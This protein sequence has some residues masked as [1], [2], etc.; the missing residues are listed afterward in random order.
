MTS[1]LTGIERPVQYLLAVTAEQP[2]HL[3]MFVAAVQGDDAR[4]PFHPARAIPLPQN[5]FE[6]NLFAMP[7]YHMLEG[8]WE[9]AAELFDTLGG[10]DDLVEMLRDPAR[11][12]QA[13]VYFSKH[14]DQ[15]ALDGVQ[16]V[17][18]N[19][20][21]H[22]VFNRAQWVVNNRRWLTDRLESTR[23][24][25]ADI[26]VVY[27]FSSQ[28]CDLE[29]VDTLAE[30]YPHLAFGAVAV[31]AASKSEKF[32]WRHAQQSFFLDQD[33]PLDPLQPSWLEQLPEAF[34]LIG[35]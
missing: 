1:N 18:E 28:H 7:Y 20:A 3:E 13:Q 24:R 21:R 10:H 33:R 5:L 17:R 30:N 26:R 12:T 27:R 16:V 34:R 2:E 4:Q 32:V 29:F 22:G 15:A 6:I 19:L 23:T 11:H 14:A 25:P 31:D 8:R 35:V 9:K